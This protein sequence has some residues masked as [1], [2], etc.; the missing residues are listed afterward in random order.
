MC[1][2]FGF[3]GKHPDWKKR[4]LA[5]IACERGLDG[6]GLVWR[7][8]NEWTGVKKGED[9][10]NLLTVEENAPKLRE[11][12]ASSVSLG[13]ARRKSPHAW[14]GGKSDDN[15]HPFCHEGWCVAHNGFV[16]NNFTLSRDYG[17]K[18]MDVDSQ[19]IP[20]V[21]AKDGI[22]GLSKIGGKAGLWAVQK[23]SGNVNL[24][25]WDQELAYVEDDD[26]FIFASDFRH[27]V[28]LG[29]KLKNVELFDDKKGQLIVVSPD[30]KIVENR[31]IRG[32]EYVY[33]SDKKG[34][35]D[36]KSSV[37]PLLIGSG[38]KLSGLQKRGLPPRVDII[39][40]ITEYFSDDYLGDTNTILYQIET[41]KYV[42]CLKC[43]KPLRDFEMSCSDVSKAYHKEPGDD[44]PC[45][46]YT[47]IPKKDELLDMLK[48]SAAED[49]S[50]VNVLGW[51]RGLE[52]CGHSIPFSACESELLLSWL[53]FAVFYG[54]E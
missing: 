22:D 54:Q 6:W 5:Y 37:G 46:G 28:A 30:G 43:K 8:A 34:S 41:G 47:C 21:L 33:E 29:H 19:V 52:M 35:K 12:F 36:S 51:I 45:G 10:R 38:R 48:S 53:V 50:W 20:Y 23:G 14:I 31:V 49:G 1:G 26:G 24:W 25:C 18:K 27:L 7:K 3:V 9:V 4:M 42:M 15:S 17:P 11:W 32:Y 40:S 16:S 2:I 39:R 44:K 13:H